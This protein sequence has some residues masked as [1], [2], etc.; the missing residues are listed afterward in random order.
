MS[1]AQA[2][3][4][5]PGSLARHA[6]RAMGTEVL[7]LLDAPDDG[8]T[9]D[10]LR[11]AEADVRRIEGLASR[12]DPA[13][14]LSALNAAGEAEVSTDL[15]RLIT[16]AL[17]MRDTTGGRFDPTVHEAVVSAGYD[18]SLDQ[19]PLDAGQ[20]GPAMPGGGGVHIDLRTGRVTLAEGTCLDLGGIA[21]GWTAD[22]IA[23]ELGVHGPCM[24]SLGGDI[25]VRGLLHG[26]PWPVEVLHADAARTVGLRRGGMAT[27]GTDRRRWRR[28]GLPMHHVID[29]HT[30]RPSDTD[31]TRVTVVADDAAAAEAWATALLVSGSERASRDAVTRGLA[32]VL[33]GIDGNVI[34]TGS[35]ADG[36][37]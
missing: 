31:L 22:R 24:V 3:S 8:A 18:R 1:T 26:E 11:R 37:A 35:L 27:S 15:L 10:A 32:A 16:L 17:E 36:Q 6:F 20:P 23:D 5:P 29:P 13:S 30:G 9:Q 19:L 25:A 14:E 12:F 33:V 34:T 7:V 28:G 2:T 21:K 4:P